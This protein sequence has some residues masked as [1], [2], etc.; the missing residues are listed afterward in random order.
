MKKFIFLLITI[1]TLSA[2]SEYSKVLNKGDV[3]SQYKL[4]EALF[5]KGKY[6][7]AM[8]LLEKVAPS[9]MNKPQLQRV[10][11]MAAISEY[12]LKNYELATYRFNR[13][14]N[15]YPKSSKIEE[16][17]YLNAQSLVNLSPRFSLDQ[18]DT[19]KALEALQTYLDKYPNSEHSDEINNQYKALVDKINKKHYEIAYQYYKTERYKAAITA[20]DN[21]LS[22]YLGTKYKEDALFYKFKAAYKLALNSVAYKKA[23]RLEEAEKAQQ[24]Y[25]KYFPDGKYSVEAKDLLEK[26]V[27]EIEI[28]NAAVTAE[29]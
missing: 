26:I 7:K 15:N 13:F 25:I 6:T 2:C 22:E 18:K 24:R 4:A 5:N 8:V 3:K 29:K 14:I 20:F 21:Y 1:I 10:R 28:T 27:K 16:A 11:Y 23:K 17:Y 19:K 12:K 9:F